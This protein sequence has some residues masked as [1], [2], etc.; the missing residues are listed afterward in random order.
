MVSSP[1]NKDP[2][3]CGIPWVDNGGVKLLGASLGSELFAD[4]LLNKRVDTM[5][6]PNSP[7]SR[8]PTLSMFFLA[9]VSP[10]QNC[11]TVFAPLTPPPTGQ[12]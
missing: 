1:Q 2:L 9:P 12:P 10:Y 3:G 11:R 4:Q 5:W 6:S 7:A 8:T